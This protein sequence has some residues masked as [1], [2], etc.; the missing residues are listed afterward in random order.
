MSAAK[1]FFVC[2]CFFTHN[3]FLK[4]FKQHVTYFGDDD[5]FMDTWSKTLENKGCTDEELPTVLCQVKAEV[6]RRRNL[7][8]Q[9]LDRTEKIS[10]GYK[11]LHPQIYTLRDSYFS[12]EFLKI[13]DYCKTHGATAEGL[14]EKLTKEEGSRVFSFP[15]FSGE[16]CDLFVEEIAHFEAS[17]LP[18]GRPN[19]M[20]NYGVLLK[21]LGFDEN[22]LDPLRTEYLLPLT[23]LLYP[24]VGGDALDSHRAFVVKYKLGEDVDLNYHYD[25]AEVTINVSL[26]KEFS[27]GELYFGDMRQIPR[28]GVKYTRFQ[29][30]R[31]FGLLHRG[32]HMH[33]AMPISDGERYNLIIWMRS[34]R[35]RNALCPMCDEEPELV[36]SVGY[37]DGF[38]S[39]GRPYR[40]SSPETVDM[41]VTL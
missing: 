21:E 23:T 36:E 28:D 4:K 15:V 32:Q 12:G 20:N 40:R 14:A 31:T 9:C 26:G 41:C 38:T 37:G 34:S 8:R 25:N 17:P 29:H 24:D 27:D 22:F 18:K 5:L 19:T 2:G 6:E 39:D 10:A 16:F 30:K 13:V 7:G 3:I 35:Q 11:S 1:R 33:G